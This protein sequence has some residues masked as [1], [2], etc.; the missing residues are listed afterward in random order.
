MKCKWI[1][2]LTA[3]IIFL[4]AVGSL[5]G[6]QK[7]ATSE[8][9]FRDIEVNMTSVES[10][11]ENQIVKLQMGDGDSAIS[12]ESNLDIEMTRNPASVHRK[13]QQKTNMAGTKET[14]EMESY[15][16][17]EDGK[18]VIYSGTDEAWE[19]NAVEEKET[20]SQQTVLFNGL[21][22]LSGAF[23]VSQDLATV[24]KEE[25]FE[26]TGTISGTQ[27]QETF[28]DTLKALLGE[29][30]S[31]LSGWNLQASEDEENNEELQQKLN[32][33]KV[34]CVIDIYRNNI[35]PAKI[36][37]DLT[38]Y[39][40][41]AGEENAQVTSYTLEVTFV[42][43][44][45]TK[46]IKVPKAVKES[47]KD[48][49]ED[50]AENSTDEMLEE[51][52]QE[53]TAEAEAAKGIQSDIEGASPQS[54]EL[55]AS[56]NSYTVQINGKVLTLPCTIADLES[57]GLTLDEKSLPQEYE[58]EAGDYQNAWFKD[59][60]KNTIMVDLI[61]TGNDVKEAKDCLVGG[62]YVEQYSLR[63]ED[64]TVIF[65]G[66]IQLGTAIDV[67]Q[68]AYGEAFQHTES[69][70]VNVYNW[71][72]DGSFYNSCEIDTNSTDGTVS[73]MGISRFEV[74][75]GE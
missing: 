52:N 34:D 39:L 49:G 46:K 30:S 25:C 42:S 12:Q 36:T 16:V 47:A 68:A 61:N 6:C 14:Q 53:A 56:W 2:K 70:L 44:N 24:N 7:A 64:L 10:A 15:Q 8:N 23:S 1:K 59:A 75:N 18:T 51:E 9:L 33:V 29:D 50:E 17:E 27:F 41:A 11:E 57:T 74:K 38:D 26:L 31:D 45:D 71:Y 40:K 21:Q 48:N 43:Y 54:E 22:N 4:A 32:N 3:G 19:K 67:V 55:G 5:S 63:N 62:I 65:P 28:A 13:G 69:E 66:G 20:S 37:F 60:S 72:E 35:L 73:M 58:I